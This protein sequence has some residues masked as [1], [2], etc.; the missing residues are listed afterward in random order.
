MCHS[1]R[2]A[3]R[4]LPAGQKKT[5]KGLS[6]KK[7]LRKRV[8]IFRK[9]KFF[10]FRLTGKYF[11]EIQK[12]GHFDEKERKNRTTTN[13]VK[14]SRMRKREKRSLLS[15]RS[16]AIRPIAERNSEKGCFSGEGIFHGTL[17]CHKLGEITA[18]SREEHGSGGLAPRR[19]SYVEE[20]Q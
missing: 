12:D 17:P 18:L 7:V 11:S 16:H 9:F 4:N 10:K 5:T 19:L 6:N 14:N 20:L 1:A 3:Q 8:E 15:W 13:I 2:L